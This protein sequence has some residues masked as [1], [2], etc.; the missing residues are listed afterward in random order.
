MPSSNPLLSLSV[1]LLLCTRAAWGLTGLIVPLYVYPT[2]NKACDQWASIISALSA[3]PHT[4]PTIFVI[5][6][7]SGPGP[8][9]SQPTTDYQQ[10]IPRLRASA[11]GS[12]TLVGYVPTGFGQRDSGAINADVDT[13]KGWASAY[14]MQGIFYDEASQAAGDEPFYQSIVTHAKNAGLSF[15]VLNPGAVPDSGYFAFADVICTAEAFYKGFSVSSL[16][17]SAAAPASKQAVILHDAPRSPSNL[18]AVIQQVSS[19]GVGWFYATNGLQ[20]GN[21]Y[22]SVPPFFATELN[23]LAALA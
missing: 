15:T 8:A 17:I 3:A 4:V 6:P 21:T 13:Y 9:G 14:A 5:N 2:N 22:G 16:T 23:D 18:S 1:L 11:G 7:Q 12:A 20:T 19:A 10:C